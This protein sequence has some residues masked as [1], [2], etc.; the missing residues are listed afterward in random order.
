VIRDAAERPRASYSESAGFGALGFALMALMGLVGGIAIARVYGVDAIGRFA[1]VMAPVNAV[2]YLSSARERP[3][4]VREIAALPA[5]APRV[6]GLFAAVLAFSFALTVVV[7]AIAIPIVYLLFRGPVGQPSLFVPAVVSLAGYTLLTNTAWNL[8]A[9]F[10]G[11]RAGRELFWIRLHQ[12]AMFLAVAVMLGGAVGGVWGLIAATLVSWATSLAHRLLAIRPYM[13]LATGRNDLRDGFRTLPELIRFG[14]KIVPGS[15]ANGASNEVG[16]WVLAVTASVAAV[17]SYNRAWTL[18]RRFVDVNWRITEMLFP[19]LVERRG[20]GD[21]AGFDRA[22]VDTIRYCAAGLL[23]PAAAGG[24]AAAGI[25][26]LYGPGFGQAAPA[27]AVL[28]AVPAVVTVASVQRHALLAVDRPGLTSMVALAKMLITVAATVVLTGRVGITGAALGVLAGACA[29][30]MWLGVPTAKTL[31]APMR[32]LW[33]RRQMA[34]IAI[35]YAAG[36]GTAHAVGSAL[37]GVG[38]LPAALAA[39]ALA[40]ALALA[41]AG[42]VNGRDRARA[43][44]LVARLR[45]RSR[46]PTP[47]SS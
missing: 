21:H 26:S 32:V 42:G 9:I 46:V 28:L 27:L 22:L 37:P 6:T 14:I 41:A 35:A 39:G 19:T 33:P 10:A 44:A 20:T 45:H 5:R 16:T 4:L 7:A 24:G 13:R 17:G 12:T 2:W 38:G 43:S 3:A 18:A 11:F 1:L 23:L 30:V 15:L 36:F 40:Y 8:D 25:M 31:S 29:E 47:V 34:A